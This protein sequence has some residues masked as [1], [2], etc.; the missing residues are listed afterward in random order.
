MVN[1]AKAIRQLVLWDEVLGNCPGRNG[2]DGRNDSLL[3]HCQQND[4]SCS[5]H[6]RQGGLV[7][8]DR[9]DMGRQGV[10]KD[11]LKELGL[12]FARLE[13]AH[14]FQEVHG[15]AVSKGRKTM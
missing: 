3:R 5:R 9:A 8:H 1:E 10:D 7:C 2:T 4:V 14:V 11:V 13:G 12:R 15:G 6:R